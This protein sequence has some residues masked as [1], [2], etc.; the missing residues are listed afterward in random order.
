[1]VREGR[2]RLIGPQEEKVTF[3]ALAVDLERD[4]TINEKR[5]AAG[6]DSFNRLKKKGE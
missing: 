6:G 3:E 4:Y 2:G 1:M 5:I